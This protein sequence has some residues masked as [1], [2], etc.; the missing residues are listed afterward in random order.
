MNIS[1]AHMRILNP[2]C[3]LYCSSLVIPTYMEENKDMDTQIRV[4]K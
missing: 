1:C 2:A 4:D 3:I